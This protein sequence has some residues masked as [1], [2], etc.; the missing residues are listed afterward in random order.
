MRDQYNYSSLFS[1]VLIWYNNKRRLFKVSEQYFATFLVVVGDVIR[2]INLSL[3][4][5]V[6]KSLIKSSQCFISSFRRS[7]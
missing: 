4:S 6:L 5:K 7:A 1:I 2:L 3:M